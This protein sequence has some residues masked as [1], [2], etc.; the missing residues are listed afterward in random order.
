MYSWINSEGQ[1][2]KTKSISE[3]ASAYGFSPSMARS[4]ACGSRA[5]LRGWCSG[6]NKPKVKKHRAR[7]T[8]VLVNTKTG[9]R[10]ILGQSVKSFAK[11]HG[12]SLQGFSELVNGRV[13]IYRHWALEKTLKAAATD[14]PFASI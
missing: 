2:I 4:L 6:S 11:K 13:P 8:T 1:T 9:E 10:C 5:R 14:T 12:L 3:F 7:F